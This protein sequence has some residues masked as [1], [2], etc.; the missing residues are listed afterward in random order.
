[1]TASEI[2]NS[3]RVCG[4]QSSCCLGCTLYREKAATCTSK[5][6]AAALML[7]LEQEKQI[8][9]L[10]DRHWNECRQIMHYDNELKGGD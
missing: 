5:L 3:L 4:T 6:A 10:T 7:I 8:E 1:M 9:D 2:K